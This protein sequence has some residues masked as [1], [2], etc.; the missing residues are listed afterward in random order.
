MQNSVD[1]H[2]VGDRTQC[3]VLQMRTEICEELGL[4]HAEAGGFSVAHHLRTAQQP[5]KILICSTHSRADIERMARLS[6][7]N[8]WVYK[9]MPPATWCEA[10]EPS[11]EG[12]R[13]TRGHKALSSREPASIHR[14]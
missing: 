10:Q 2:V 8:G 13:F 3:E 6:A 5:V 1:M 7:C 4:V 14:F 9:P 12:A 11:C